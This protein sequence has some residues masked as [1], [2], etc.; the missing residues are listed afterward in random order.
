MPAATAIS[1]ARRSRPAAGSSSSRGAK[2]RP[3][4]RL[5]RPLYR[6]GEA[7]RSPTLVQG[8]TSAGLRRP[9]TAV[10][11]PHRL[12]VAGDGRPAAPFAGPLRAS[13][14]PDEDV[15]GLCGFASYADPRVV[16]EEA[17]RDRP[18]VLGIIRGPPGRRGARRQG[19]SGRV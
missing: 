5:W 11:V 13:G 19:G 2:A 1:T 9:R 18:C 4:L 10:A 3:A 14:D 7:E 6:L 17:P 12:D 15:V 8:R 16:G